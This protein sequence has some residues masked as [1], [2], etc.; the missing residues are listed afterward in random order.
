MMRTMIVTDYGQHDV[1]PK[2]EAL[3]ERA[4]KNRFGEVDGRSRAAKLLGRYYRMV[5]AKHR[6]EWLEGK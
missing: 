5:N 1:S 4:P 6:R 2:F 3:I